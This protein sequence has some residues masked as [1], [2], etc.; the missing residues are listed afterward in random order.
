MIE[1]KQVLF[2]RHAESIANAGGRTPNVETIALSE[3]GKQQALKLVE[4]IQ[5]V[6]EL[7]IV[8]PYIRTSLTAEPLIKKHNIT[9]IQVWE[10]VKELTYLD[11]VKYANTTQAE[12]EV[13][14]KEFWQRNDPNFRDLNGSE[15]FNDLIGRIKLTLQKI[16]NLTE[17]KIAVFTHGQFLL[18][19]RMYLLHGDDKNLMSKFWEEY[20]NYPIGNAQIFTFEDLKR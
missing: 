16:E 5:I 20:S 11:R 1:N 19:L 7:V 13:G 12:R 17:E 18:A 10:E 2:I 6:P 15:S 9:N 8:S 3:R 14:V 4:T